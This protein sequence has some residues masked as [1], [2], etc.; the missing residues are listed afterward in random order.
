MAR[1][2]YALTLLLHLVDSFRI[3]AV[4]GMSN[5]PLLQRGAAVHMC[6]ADDGGAD[7][8]ECE[9]R[10]V[11]ELVAADGGVLPDRFMIAVQAIRGDFSPP[12]DEPDD[13]R[14]EDLIFQAL[15]DFPATVQLK[16]VSRAVPEEQLDSLVKDVAK[17]CE[18]VDATDAAW[19]AVRRGSRRSIALS[20]RVPSALAL[21]ELR[22]A[23]VKD[24]R[25]Q[26]VF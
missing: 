21:A 16:V 11:A 24:P 12:D 19:K 15:T 23:L 9:G 4:H 1:L 25:V 10:V 14:Q 7:D 2:L 13:E 6:A 22:D 26:M 3:P 17:L 18:C 5:R 8:M 20:I